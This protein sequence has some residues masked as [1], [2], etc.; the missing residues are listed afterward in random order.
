MGKIMSRLS[1]PAKRPFYYP[2]YN[3]ASM[4]VFK[5][6]WSFSFNSVYSVFSPVFLFDSDCLLPFVAALGFSLSLCFSPSLSLYPSS[7]IC[8]LL[9][10]LFVIIPWEAVFSSFFLPFL[11]SFIPLLLFTF[12]PFSSL[13][14]L[15]S[16]L[17]ILLLHLFLSLSTV[18]LPS[19]L[20]LLT[21]PSYCFFTLFFTS[22]Y[23]PFPLISSS[24]YPAIFP[25]FLFPAPSLLIASLLNRFSFW[26]KLSLCLG[27]WGIINKEFFYSP[28]L[29]ISFTRMVCLLIL[30][31]F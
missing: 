19:F 4:G 17:G 23:P 13:T 28:F 18:F 26:L 10:T 8:C 2:C 9:L 5:P 22:S 25:P 21:L 20:L 3:F 12:S 14:L 1:F 6:S 27:L 7:W 31:P 16:A 29:L 30:L 24:A 11:L 15:S